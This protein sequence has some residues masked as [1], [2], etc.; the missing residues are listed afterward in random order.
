L[1]SA[2]TNYYVAAENVVPI[3]A[4]IGM[5]SLTSSSYESP[6]YHLFGGLKSQY[7]IRASELQAAGLTA[8][9]FQLVI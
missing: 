9:Q 4:T 8:D 6:F 7:L 1:I 2:T 3:N 5:G